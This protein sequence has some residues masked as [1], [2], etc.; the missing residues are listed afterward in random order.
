MQKIGYYRKS[1]DLFLQNI[2]LKKFMFLLHKLEK[3]KLETKL[4][5]DMVTKVLF[6]EF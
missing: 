6:Q 5:D 3:F 1:G 2:N 4:R